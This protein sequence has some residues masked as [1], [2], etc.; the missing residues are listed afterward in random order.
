MITLGIAVVS[1]LFALYSLRAGA[2]ILALMG[3][4]V[5]I[6]SIVALSS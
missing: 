2:F 1:G 3:A 4:A 5:C 6:A